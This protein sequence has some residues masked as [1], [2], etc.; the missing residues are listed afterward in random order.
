MRTWRLNVLV[1]ITAIFSG[2][3]MPTLL[4]TAVP[5]GLFFFLFRD[6]SLGRLRNGDV[7]GLA[8]RFGGK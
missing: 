4:G 1:E 6:P 7:V 2:A 5:A 3:K 8:S